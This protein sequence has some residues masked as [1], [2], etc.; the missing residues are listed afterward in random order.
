MEQFVLVSLQ[1]VSKSDAFLIVIQCSIMVV[2]DCRTTAVFDE[3]STVEQFECVSF[4][5]ILNPLHS[6][7]MPLQD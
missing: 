1:V 4:R 3:F 2:K 7:C 6:S 5:L